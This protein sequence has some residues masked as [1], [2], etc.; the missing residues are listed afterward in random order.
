MVES[1]S[2][3]GGAAV[4]VEAPTAETVPDE[5]GEG[6]VVLG[7]LDE[8]AV[9]PALPAPIADRTT[10]GDAL[11]S[12]DVRAMLVRSEAP[13]LAAVAA[14]ADADLIQAVRLCAGGD[15]VATAA[16][17]GGEDLVGV[18]LEEAEAAQD[19]GGFRGGGVLHL[20]YTGL[21]QELTPLGPGSGSVATLA[22]A[23]FFDAR[24]IS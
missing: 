18:E 7:D 22:G 16:P 14:D 8:L 13:A 5:P 24:I 10:L 23:I 4:G 19:V 15:D 21:D 9:P 6:L 2:R 20:R 1:R 12:D 3:L 11:G 17:V